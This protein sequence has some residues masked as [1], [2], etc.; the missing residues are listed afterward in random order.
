MTPIGPRSEGVLGGGGFEP[1]QTRAMTRRDFADVR[2]WHRTAA[3][4]ARD[5]GFDIVY[6]YAAHGLTLPMQL[7]SR[8]HNDRTDEYGGIARATAC[9]SCASS[10]RTPRTP[11]ATTAPWPCASPSTSCVGPEGI[12]H[13]GEGREIVAMLAELPDLWDVNVAGW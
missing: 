7:L 9:A 11:S 1:V 2:R 5:A 4:R 10:S 3:L 13:D 6:C 12:T 8:R